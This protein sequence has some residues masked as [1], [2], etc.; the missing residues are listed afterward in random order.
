MQIT[1]AEA[2]HQ[3]RALLG[4][5]CLSERAKVFDR[6]AVLVRWVAK[7]N[8]VNRL[9]ILLGSCCLFRGRRVRGTEEGD[10]TLGR[11]ECILVA[12]S[13]GLMERDSVIHIPAARTWRKWIRVSR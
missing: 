13:R 10:P 7:D 12:I 8:D 9:S 11:F 1:D 2:V 6:D 4:L 5:C 3:L